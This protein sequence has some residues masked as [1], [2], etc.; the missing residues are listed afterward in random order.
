MMAA[1]LACGRGTVLSHQSAAVL[2]GLADRAP[3]VVDVIAPGNRGRKIDGIRAHPVLPPTP[4]EV[5]RVDAI[6]CTSP[7]RTLVD[8]A[9]M[10]GE[11]TLRS[12]FECLAADRKLDLVAVEVAA[13]RCRRPGKARLLAICAEWRAATALVPGA[14][15]RSPFEARLLPLLAMT[16]MPAPL[17][18]E[19]VDTP[20]G[21]LVVDLLWPKYRFVVEADSRRHHGT[22][23]AFERDRWRDRELMRA[24]YQTLRPTWHQAEHE[25]GAVLDAIATHLTTPH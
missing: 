24:G 4:A 21:R 6:P 10:V 12:G 15:L 22:D 9:A 1:V 2:L 16:D 18:N 7:A 23:M 25:P 13:Q 5:G 17:V 20:G 8:L 3:A 11:R 14:R 19:P